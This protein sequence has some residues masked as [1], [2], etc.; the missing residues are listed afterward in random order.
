VSLS[1]ALRLLGCLSVT[2]KL[3]RT[4]ILVST[5]NDCSNSFVPLKKD[6]SSRILAKSTPSLVVFAR[7]IEKMR[8]QRF[9]T[10]FN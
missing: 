6:Y 1:I 2:I 9:I 3:S 4:K 10:L 8:A 7:N 5:I